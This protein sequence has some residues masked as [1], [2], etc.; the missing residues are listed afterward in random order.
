M[1]DYRIESDLI[2]ELKVPVNAYYGVQTQ[3]AI[4]NFKISNDH[5]SD[6]PE[7]IKA[8][9]FVKKAAAQTNFELGL[10][11]EIINKNIAIACDEIVAGKMHEQFPT[12]MIQGGAGTSMN[13]NANEVIANRALEL[14]GHQKGEY[15]FC[16]PNDHVNL[17]QSTNDAYPTAIRI[18]LYNL[19][20]TLVERLELLIQSFRKKADDLKDVIKMGRTQLQDAVP[21]TMGQEFN[22]F[23]N[24]LQEEIARLNTNADLFLETN[25]GAT[26]IGTGLNAHPDYATK[27]TENL[28]KISGADVVLASDLVEATPD[29]GA[30]VIYSSAMKRMA[31]KLS[32]ICN[33][34]RLLASGPR[35]GFY[36]INLPKMQPGSSIMPGKVNPVIPE[37]VN[38]V[39]FKVIGNDL[40]VTFAAEAGQLQL[41]VMEPVL[42]QSIMES[43]R[44]LKNAMDTLREKCIDGITAN[45][46]ICLN[47]VKN[48]IGIVT[49]LNPYI[50]YK[51]STKIAKEALD[52]GKS[53]YDLVLEHEL[54]SKEKLDEI[55][56]P[57]N[58]LNPHAKF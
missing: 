38:Q 22:A 24:T 9:A 54:L 16:S 32:K 50:G 40:T 47:M 44:F 52:T 43:I 6:H 4:D 34:L 41:N 28:A 13:M 2:G 15:Q 42:T 53:V 3:R 35:A 29:T 33:D 26:A 58:M 27:C 5:L 49:A 25:M 21:M 14:M 51:N 55:L 57:E 17:S 56:A 8:F 39:C 30:Y 18:A 37:V 36:E 46:E 45:K 11:D 1:N 10:L 20:K 12:D 48:S 23:A 19:N 7:F 31:V